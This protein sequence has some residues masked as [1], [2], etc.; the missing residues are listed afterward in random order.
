MRK[1]FLNNT[2]VY[3]ILIFKNIILIKFHKFLIFIIE[4]FVRN[5]FKCLIR[6]LLL[7]LSLKARFRVILKSSEIKR[8]VYIIKR[9]LKRRIRLR[10]FL[11][12]LTI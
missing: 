12:L 2:I 3:F 9:R 1:R 8:F 6:F 11:R 5:N 4:I 10:L 7:R